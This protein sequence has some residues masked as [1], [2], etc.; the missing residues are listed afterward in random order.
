[1]SRAGSDRV[2]KALHNVHGQA[3][4]IYRDEV[5][6]YTMRLTLGCNCVCCGLAE[7]LAIG[8][9]TNDGCKAIGRETG[10]IGRLDLRCD[11]TGF[12][13][14]VDGHPVRPRPGEA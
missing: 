12:T 9:V 14:T 7:I 13:K 6:R 2:A 5:E 10:D 1:M 4:T 11:R 8:P 3:A